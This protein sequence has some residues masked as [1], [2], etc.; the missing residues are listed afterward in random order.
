MNLV[1]QREKIGFIMDEATSV[2]FKA[3]SMD[4]VI[5]EYLLSKPN[6]HESVQKKPYPISTF[7]AIH[8]MELMSYYIELG[9][10]LELFVDHELPYMYW[11]LGEVISLWRHRFWS[12]SKEYID[13]ERVLSKFFFENR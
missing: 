13:M 3:E 1:R 12:K 4:K 7:F 2:Y 10:K 11:Y 9:F 5:A 8:F 6:F